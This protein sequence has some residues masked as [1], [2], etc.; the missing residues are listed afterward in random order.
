[1]NDEKTSA[2]DRQ[3][4]IKAISEAVSKD[5][6]W[7]ARL[8]AAASLNG[9]KDAKD[10]LLAATKDPNA[11]VRAR[12]VTSLAATKDAALA[13]TYQQL[14]SDQS[15]AVI[16]AAAVALGQTRSAGAYDSLVKLIDA[17]SWRDT[18]RASALS[19]LAALGDQRA[20]ALGLKYSVAGNRPAVRASALAVL[21]SA[22]KDD[23]RVFPILS[24]LLSEA[25]EKRN[26]SLFAGAAEALVSLGDERGLALFQELSKKP[27]T[28]TQMVAA[29][30]GFESRLRAKLAPAKPAS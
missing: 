5:Q 9:L 6:F 20:L 12:A 4:I 23:P 7:G 17:P 2:A 30:S 28:S 10:A 29:I 25:A 13:D 11:R 24:T 3:A 15:Y 21:G 19:G 26:F 8:E 16:R 1:M 18:I 27:G 22:G 14:L